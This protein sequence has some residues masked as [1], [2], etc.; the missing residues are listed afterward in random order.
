MTAC[1]VGIALFM[2]AC[3]GC[4]VCVSVTAF[5]RDYGKMKA[6]GYREGGHPYPVKELACDFLI[7]DP[8]GRG[9]RVLMCAL[10]F[11]ISCVAVLIVGVAQSL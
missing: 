3:T 5:W 7:H 8:A 9:R 6:S 2:I 11:A 1:L 4:F 10:L